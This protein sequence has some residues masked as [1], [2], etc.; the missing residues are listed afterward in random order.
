MAPVR[1]CDAAQLPADIHADG[2]GDR[3]RQQGDV[4]AVVQPKQQGQ[5]QNT[6]QAGQC[7]CKNTHDDGKYIFAQ[8][9]PF[10]VQG[11]ARLT[12]AGS[13]R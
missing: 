8:Q 6:A 2:C 13:S 1:G 11:T 10:F 4:L 9:V 12:V 5:H 7:A 3:L